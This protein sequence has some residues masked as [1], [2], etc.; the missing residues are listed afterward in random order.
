MKASS[1]KSAT[2]VMNEQEIKHR[3]HLDVE[4]KRATKKETC[5]APDEHQK[6]APKRNE[7]QAK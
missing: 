1:A 4:N 7:S 6:L 5:A 3:S 2:N